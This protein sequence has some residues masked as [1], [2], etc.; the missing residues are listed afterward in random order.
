MQINHNVSFGSVVAVS[1]GAKQIKKLNK[2]LTIL[3]QNNDH[4]IM[5]DVTAHY[6]NAKSSGS[7]AQAVQNGDS[8]EIYISGDDV[9]KVKQQAKNWDTLDG[10]LS[11]LSGYCNMRKSSYNDIINKIFLA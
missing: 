10:I 9:K 6:K 3:T 4:V 7:L 8:L 1:G 11:H 2:K 5:K